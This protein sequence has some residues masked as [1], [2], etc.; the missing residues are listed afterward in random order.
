MADALTFPG[1]HII[2][3]DEAHCPEC[4][5]TQPFTPDGIVTDCAWCGAR[6]VVVTVERE[7]IVSLLPKASA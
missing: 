1:P 7:T 5:H 3:A 6:F 4:H 2:S